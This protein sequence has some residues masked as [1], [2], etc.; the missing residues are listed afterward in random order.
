MLIFF[1]S[2]D[3]LK[4]NFFKKIKGGARVRIV[5][6]QIKKNLKK[7]LDFLSLNIYNFIGRTK[8]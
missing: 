6:V 3:L 7:T 8:K 4:I 1:F 2:T 5:V